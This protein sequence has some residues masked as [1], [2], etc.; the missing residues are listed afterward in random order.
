MTEPLLVVRSRRVV[1]DS[2]APAAI[3]VRAGT[4]RQADQIDVV[5]DRVQHGPQGTE[6]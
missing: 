2:I 6:S 4:P 5:E 3:H 1:T